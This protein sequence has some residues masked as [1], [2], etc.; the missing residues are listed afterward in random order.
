MGPLLWCLISTII[1]KNCKRK[2]HETTITTP[3]SKKIVS[4]LRLAFVD[5]ADL[6][7]TA[8]N[9]YQSGVEMIK[10][11]QVL[12]TKCCGCICAA[13]GL[14]ASVKTRWFLVSFFWHGNDWYYKITDSLPGDIALSDKDDNLYTVNREELTA[15]FESLGL[16]I[17]LTNISLKVLDDVTLIYQGYSTQINN[18]K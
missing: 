6:V 18:A 12:M 14:I 1:I 2:D 17:N 8:K 15:P 16:Q 10:K 7:T 13:G 11:M 3:I 5:D 9:A 4:L